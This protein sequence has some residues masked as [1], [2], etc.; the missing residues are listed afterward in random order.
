[1]GEAL[2]YI[3]MK[4]DL[5]LHNVITFGIQVNTEIKGTKF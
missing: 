4:F 2:L 1:M 3:S 5:T